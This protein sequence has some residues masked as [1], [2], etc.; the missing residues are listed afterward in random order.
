MHER[1]PYIRPVKSRKIC[2]LSWT[3]DPTLRQQRGQPAGLLRD[4]P[5]PDAK[6]DYPRHR[7]VQQLARQGWSRVRKNKILRLAAT[8]VYSVQSHGAAL[9]SVH[10]SRQKPPT[11][12]KRQKVVHGR[13][14][15]GYDAQFVDNGLPATRDKNCNGFGGQPAL[16]ASISLSLGVLWPSRRRSGTKPAFALTSATSWWAASPAGSMMSRYCLRFDTMIPWRSS[17]SYKLVV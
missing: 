9:I 14:Y 5:R 17:R 3:P 8:V 2:N 4:L 13:L 11:G 10:T 12:Q 16:T 6:L 7:S 15:E 1:P